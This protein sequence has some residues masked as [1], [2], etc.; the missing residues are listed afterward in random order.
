MHLPVEGF[1][2]L[3]DIQ[4]AITNSLGIDSPAF[5][6]MI[7][8]AYE[9]V[10]KNVPPKDP[11]NSSD[12]SLEDDPPFTLIKSNLEVERERLGMA[13][14]EGTPVSNQRAMEAAINTMNKW[15]EEGVYNKEINNILNDAMGG[16]VS[17]E[18]Q[19]IFFAKVNLILEIQK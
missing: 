1:E 18:G 13:K 9:K 16:D 11:I 7:E 6:K 14:F 3:D 17:D 4:E 10:S 5:R 8:D 15:K 2:D 12:N 19:N